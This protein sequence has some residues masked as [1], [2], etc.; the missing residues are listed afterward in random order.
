M[1]NQT[2]GFTRQEV[3]AALTSLRKD[4]LNSTT[5]FAFAAGVILR[6]LWLLFLA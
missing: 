6:S 5:L 1:S 3:T 2:G 4:W